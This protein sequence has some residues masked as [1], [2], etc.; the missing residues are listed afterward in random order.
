MRVRLSSLWRGLNAG[1]P[2][3]AVVAAVALLLLAAVI[4]VVHFSAKAEDSPRANAGPGAGSKSG[5]PA[6][7]DVLTQPR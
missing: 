1:R 2:R 7:V 5:A 3:R 6:L 4:G